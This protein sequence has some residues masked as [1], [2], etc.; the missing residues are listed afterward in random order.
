MSW[1]VVKHVMD[2]S[3]SVGTDRLVLL[4]LA[5]SA[6][7][8]SWETWIGVD[9]IRSKAGV[10]TDRTIQRSLRR[11]EETNELEV[12][13]HGAPQ[14]DRRFQY[15]T[16]LYRI[17]RPTFP[18]YV[19]SSGDTHDT[20]SSGLVVTS[21]ASSGDIGGHL[22]VTP[23]SPKPELEPSLETTTT[24]DPRFEDAVK[25]SAHHRSLLPWVEN[26]NGVKVQTAKK[27]RA[28]GDDGEALND[29]LGKNP[30][31]TADDAGRAYADNEIP[32]TENYLPPPETQPG[33]R[34]YCYEDGSAI[35]MRIWS[36]TG[37]RWSEKE[38]SEAQKKPSWSPSLHENPY[39]PRYDEQ[40]D[41]YTK[42]CQ[43]A[44]K[45]DCPNCGGDGRLIVATR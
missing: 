25:R 39:E 20:T 3:R 16:N 32:G 11:L 23:V 22:V 45:S 7:K 28:P 40:L 6:N 4:A 17:V 42:P 18:A 1:E 35:G 9:T 30:D 33:Q 14:Y 43:C 19:S 24:R 29:W 13:I 8:A 5:E 27:L 38:F 2:K 36:D 26:P 21:G 34:S 37:E 44:G 41:A 12:V 15:R 10:K 31:A